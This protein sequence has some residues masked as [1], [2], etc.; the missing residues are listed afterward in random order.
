MNGGDVEEFWIQLNLLTLNM[1]LLMWVFIMLLLPL[2][3]KLCK[4]I[5]FIIH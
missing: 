3:I 1:L 2:L 4:Y 5:N